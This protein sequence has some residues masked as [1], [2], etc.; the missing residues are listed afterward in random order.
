M[1]SVNCPG[2]TNPRSIHV[3]IKPLA[4]R[5]RTNPSAPMDCYLSSVLFAMI[6]M[7]PSTSPTSFV[8]RFNT[9]N[10]FLSPVLGRYLQLQAPGRKWALPSQSLPVSGGSQHPVH[11][12]KL[13]LLR[14]HKL[15]S[16]RPKRIERRCITATHESC[17]PIQLVL[18]SRVRS[19]VCLFAC[20][21][22]WCYDLSTNVAH[23]VYSV[24]NGDHE[25]HAAVFCLSSANVQQ[26]VTHPQGGPSAKYRSSSKIPF[27]SFLMLGT[28]ICLTPTTCFS[29]FL[30]RCFPMPVFCKLKSIRL[31]KTTWEDPKPKQKRVCLGNCTKQLIWNNFTTTPV[32][33]VDLLQVW[34]A[35]IRS[36][37]ACFC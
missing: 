20:L 28:S 27:W 1:E 22:V 37:V 6:M 18:G 2:E 26:L 24:I 14:S 32:L 21:S 9:S 29:G 8:V 3:S 35:N 12:D 30:H 25:N 5:S 19:T 7:P 34:G 10:C 11:L 17:V 13:I 36:T 15:D 4:F 16:T 33:Q 31:P 23:L